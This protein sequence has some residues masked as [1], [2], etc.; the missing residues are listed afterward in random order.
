MDGNVK[1]LS[2]ERACL[3]EKSTFS[4]AGAAMTGTTRAPVKCGMWKIA[5]V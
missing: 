3:L 4:T 5:N 2:E 1:K